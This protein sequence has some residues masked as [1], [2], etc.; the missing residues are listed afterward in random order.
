M[1][2][3]QTL[4]GGGPRTIYL[5]I[6][7]NT[8]NYNIRTS[9]GSP[10]D[11]SDVTLTINSGV[12]VYSTSTVSPSLNTG[13]G[14]ASGS[15]IRII[16][17]GNIYGCGGDGGGGG[18]FDQRD[19]VNGDNGG[20]AINI[21]LDVIIDNT[22]GFIFGGGGGG[23]GGATD[24]RGGLG[25][26]PGGGGGGGQGRNGGNGGSGGSG[27][28]VPAEDGTSGDTTSAGSG[29]AGGEDGFYLEVGGSG[30]GGGGWGSSANDG[31]DTPNYSGGSG[32]SGG[33]AIDLNGYTVTWLGGNTAARVKGAVS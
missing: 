28:G 33:K 22:N 13:T 15:V 26:A 20:E 8:S 27:G 17:N 1:T 32:G 14:W 9:A 25:Y 4:L 6:S 29:G 30:G 31:E 5:T 21:N 19:G 2:I 11:I 18:D 12:T 16:N 23:G 7:G 24:A 3:Q 10:S